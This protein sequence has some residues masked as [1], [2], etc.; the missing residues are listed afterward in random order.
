[1]KKEHLRNLM[2]MG[3]FTFIL[4]PLALILMNQY[5]EKR[6][7]EEVKAAYEV[8]VRMADSKWL[9]REGKLNLEELNQI[10]DAT[11]SLPY[12]E[13]EQLLGELLEGKEKEYLK[14]KSMMESNS[15]Q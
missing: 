2:L 10:N 5:V 3:V 7:R 12:E 8:G 6:Q 9:Y 13:L 4:M 1:M 15:I 11:R 14:E